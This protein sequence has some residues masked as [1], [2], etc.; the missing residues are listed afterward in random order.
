MRRA[1]SGQDACIGGSLRQRQRHTALILWHLGLEDV[2]AD[3]DLDRPGQR[4]LRSQLLGGARDIARHR[5]L[6]FVEVFDQVAKRAGHHDLLPVRHHLFQ[7][8]AGNAAQFSNRALENH[9]EPGA[10]G[11]GIRITQLAHR[12]DT[13]C[14][15]PGI[16]LAPDTPDLADLDPVEQRRQIIPVQCG[17]IT[18]PVSTGQP[19]LGAGFASFARVLVGA[20]PTHTAKPSQSAIRCRISAP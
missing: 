7:V 13:H 17:E 1:Q 2:G 11:L 4:I 9:R 3:I 19:F 20:M 6:Q 12:P 10:D 18:D 16:D 8:D 15:E 14:F 5:F